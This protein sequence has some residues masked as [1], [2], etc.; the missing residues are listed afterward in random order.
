MGI[1][2]EPGYLP[3]I[4]VSTQRNIVSIKG[5]TLYFK[6][7]EL[8]VYRVCRGTADHKAYSEVHLLQYW[9]KGG[10]IIM[11]PK[12]GKEVTN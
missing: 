7:T 12:L 8:D 10:N 3:G 2:D 11:H 9:K 4:K 5:N 1:W 6:G